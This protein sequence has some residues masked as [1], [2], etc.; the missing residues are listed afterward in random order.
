MN[1]KTKNLFFF[2]FF[3]A[4]QFIQA[5]T[6]TLTLEVEGGGQ[7][8]ICSGEPIQI[9]AIVDPPNETFTTNWTRIVNGTTT[10]I[11]SVNGDE[12]TF[13]VFDGGDL[14]TENTTIRVE[15]FGTP[16]GNLDKSINIEVQNAPN[17][18]S[19]GDLLLCNK[20]GTIDLFTILRG[21]PDTGGTW[22]PAL[23]GGEGMFVVGT[24]PAGEYTYTQPGT[25]ACPPS[26]SKV[27]V[28]DCFDNDFDDDG[29]PNDVDLDDDNDGILDSEENSNCDENGLSET[30]PLVDID[31]GTGNIPTNDTNVVGHGYTSEW[32]NDG[33]YNVGTSNYFLSRAAFAVFVATDLNPIANSDGNGDVNGR[34]LAINV[35]ENFNNQI[36]YQIPDIRIVDGTQYNFRID[37]AGLCNDEFDGSPCPDEPI[38]DLELIDQSLPEGSPPIFTQSSADLGVRNDDLWKTLALNFEAQT[39]TFLTLNIINRQPN[40][41][42]GNDIGID[43]IRFASLEC[44]TDRDEIP[45]FIDLDSDQ[46]GIFDV[47]EA[48]F[49]NLDADGNGTVD[50]PVDANG[51]P[52]AANGGLT[53]VNSNYLDI[54]SDN[55]GIT[56]NIEAQTTAGYIPPSGNDS[57]RNGV[58]DAYEGANNIDPNNVDTDGD[59]TPDYLDLNSDDDCLDDTIEAYD[60][61]QDGVADIIAS[62]IDT[63]GD[64][65]DDAFDSVE[66]GLLTAFMNASNGG[67]LPTDLPDFTPPGDDVDFRQEYE[68]INEEQ[69]LDLCSTTG[70]I[71][72]FDILEEANILGGVW[73]GPSDLTGG[74]QGT[75]D[76]E[77]NVP[78]EYTYTL[79]QIATCPARLA[80]VTVTQGTLPNAGENETIILCTEAD[81]VNLFE[82]LGGTPD[83]GGTWTDPNDVALGTDDQ[84]NID[85]ETAVAGVYTYTVGSATCNSTA[86]VNVTLEDNLSAGNNGTVELC[87]NATAINL[88]ESLEGSPDMGGT[89]TD[90]NN[91]PFGTGDNA[92]IDPAD[93]T[94][95][96]GNYT[97]SVSSANCTMPSTATVAVT[98][99]TLPSAGNSSTIT[100]CTEADPVN[101][102]ERLDGT[103][104]MGGT[105][106]DP[107]SVALGTD[108]LGNIDPETAV[109]GVYTYTVGSATCN[110]TATVNV[111]LEDNLSAGN[112]G[113]AELC[114]NATA[115]NLFESLEGTPDMGGT[116]TD[117]NNNPFGTGDDATI[118]PADA[119]TLS[120]NYTYSVSSANCTMPSTATVAVTI[121]T[122][123]SAGTDNS[124]NL[125]SAEDPVNLFER[126]GGTP[127]MGGTW[128]DPNNNPFGTGDE[129][130]FN[131]A[132]GTAGIYTYTIGTA[133]CNSTATVD[134]TISN[135]SDSG[136][137]NTIVFC[138]TDTPENLFNILGGTPSAGG[139][140]TDP[141]DNPFGTGDNAT[142]DPTDL[143][144][145]QGV[146]TYTV[147][148]A[149][150]PIPSSSRVTISIET[151]PQLNFV[152]TSCSAD[153]ASYNITYTTNGN[154]NITVTPLGAAVIDTANSMITGIAAETD[155][156]ITAVNPANIVCTTDLPVTAPDCNCPDIVEPTNPSNETICEGTANPTLSVDVLAGQTANWYNQDGS[157]LV[158]GTTTFTPTDTAP[159]NYTYSVEAFDT[160]EGCPS[161]RVNVNFNIV[162]TPTVTGLAPVQACESFT[163]PFL[164]NGNYFTQSNGA[165]TRFNA[166]D[167]ITT[168]QTLFIYA[169]TGTTPN[170]TAEVT[171]DIT[172][173]PLPMPVAPVTNADRFCE[174]YTLPDFANN[175]QSYFTGINGTGTQLNPGD[176][177][178]DT[179]SLY[180]RE[181]STTTGCENEVLFTVNID[182]ITDILLDVS[183]IICVDEDGIPLAGNNFPEIDTFL[184]NNDYDF[185][186]SFEGTNIAGETNA[187][188]VATQA[189]E[190]TVEYTDVITRCSSTATAMVETGRGPISV[191]LSVSNNEFTNNRNNITATVV[192]DGDYSY[193]LDNGTPQDSNVFTDVS[194]G[195]HRVTVFDNRG[196]SD[197][198]EEIFV[199]GFPKFFTPNGDG[200]NDTWNIVADDTL[201]EM[202]IYIFDRYGKLVKEMTAN[203]IGWD[204]TY[205]GE[206]LPTTDYWFVAEFADGSKTYKNH[207]TLRR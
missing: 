8:T 175:D 127:D 163:L 71:N 93:A 98:I 79:P 156:V 47:V 94:I 128:T 7:P 75:Y 31:F 64:G 124:T 38:L 167:V 39:T 152:S 83:M 101:L 21:G 36:L 180:L 44:D 120:G 185:V 155:V 139:S 200:F 52:V 2:L 192:G 106:T 133:T 72:L 55:D 153:R 15:V 84:G 99:T 165:G 95:L 29:V 17:P 126:L 116:W 159:G 194:L 28:R 100:L 69:P 6:T 182:T 141:N 144:T 60:I 12:G 130:V 168:S 181:I 154:W 164:T 138:S 32:P 20:S 26:Q 117:P 204:G 53:P 43:N 136:V 56:D 54:D 59:T 46:D 115:I 199:I 132:S 207:F 148:T 108:D 74:D 121:T 145:I 170:C 77:T 113:T 158:L 104:D 202:T 134:V 149:N 30:L 81:P 171:L 5:Q 191:N 35:A 61:N 179:Q 201:S 88:F 197:I 157:V 125:C 33:T 123:P 161:D 63:D 187:T 25:A 91:N 89:W 151:T 184:D 58:D 66:L 190:Y 140:W 109:A 160:T 48:G 143:N 146:Y 3:I 82:S 51:I 142:I 107:N 22:S 41:G 131:P 129:A 118:D 87:S 27:I 114:S 40:G 76:P 24:D 11:K 173:N 9:N 198:I 189:G 4:F 147:T 14:L 150:C 102:F 195:L 65:L 96:S 68:A 73:T 50:G 122:L 92:T 172:I 37:L 111:T 206:R 19:E 1:T 162:A 203:D 80:V 110:S 169:E 23:S 13:H 45:N 119:T 67:V 103:P 78:G 42:D 34:Y 188:I 183:G 178:E 186:W 105:W 135:S 174:S 62:G 205:R 16:S 90:P 85:P 193:S 177:I 112:N 49:G 70:N 18:G 166:G 196:C 97:Y 57:N 86:T 137:D 10:F 176:I